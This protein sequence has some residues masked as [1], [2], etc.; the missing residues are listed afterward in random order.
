MFDIR[1]D[2]SGGDLPS[3]PVLPPPASQPGV[4]PPPAPDPAE[5]TAGFRGALQNVGLELEPTQGPAEF[6]VIDHVE[7]PS[8]N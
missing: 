5:I 1:L 8:E 3:G 6:L 2:W 7:R 4:P